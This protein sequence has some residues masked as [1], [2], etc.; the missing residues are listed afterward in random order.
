[1]NKRFED[2]VKNIVGEEEM[3]ALRKHEAFA[4]AMKQFDQEVKPNFTADPN[5]SWFVS[6]P[7]AKL[8][9]DPDND[10]QSDFLN[11]KW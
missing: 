10:L 7:M 2:Y 1:M 3:F 11:L 9:D 6:F 8:A 5:K 4:H